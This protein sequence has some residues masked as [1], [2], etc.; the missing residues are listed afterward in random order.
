MTCPGLP[1]GLDDAFAD[2]SDCALIQRTLMQALATA[3]TGTITRW[4]NTRSGVNGTIKL[5]AAAARDGAVCRR[6]EFTVVR[7]DG[8]KR[9]EAVACLKDGRWTIVE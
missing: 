3:E 4:T 1:K 5:A 7:V 9:A 8:T 6:A 2:A